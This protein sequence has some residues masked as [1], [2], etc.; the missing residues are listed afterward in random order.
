MKANSSILSR[1]AGFLLLCAT[2]IL[3][4]TSCDP[5][6]FGPGY[7]G[8][9]GAYA[10]AFGRNNYFYYPHYQTYF[11]PQTNLYHYRVGNNWASGPR[12]LNVNYNVFRNSPSVPLYLNSHPQYHHNNVSNIYPHNWRQPSNWHR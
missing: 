9:Y 4:L 2:V 11:H 6:F 5:A 8:G 10:P 1:K 3:S 7:G 12:P